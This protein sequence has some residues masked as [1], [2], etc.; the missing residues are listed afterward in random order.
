MRGEVL[1][2]SACRTT[3]RDEQSDFHSFRVLKS[4]SLINYNTLSKYA[5]NE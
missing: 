5:Q 4:N 3:S 2:L 1:A